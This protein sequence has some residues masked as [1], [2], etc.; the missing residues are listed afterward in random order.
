MDATLPDG[1]APPAIFPGDSGSVPNAFGI[2]TRLYPE[3][4]VALATIGPYFAKFLNSPGKIS[5]P[6][7]FK[8]DLD[9]DYQRLV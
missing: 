6:Q 7:F 8:I 5:A 2:P 3:N 1:Q 9:I 4:S